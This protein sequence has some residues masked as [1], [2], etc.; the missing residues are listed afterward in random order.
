[1]TNPAFRSLRHRPF[2]RF[3][4]GQTVSIIGFWTQVVAL[5]W[6]VYRLTGST[7]M[8]GLV[9]FCNSIPMLLV[10][11]F[12]GVLVDRFDRRKVAL[13]TQ[14]VQMLQAAIL[15]ALSFTGTLRVEYI[16][17]LALLYGV[18][19]SFDAPARQA[20]LPVMVGGRNDLPNAIALNSA[21]MNLGRFVGPA[22]A[23]ALL[24]VLGEG[25]CFAVNALSFLAVLPALWVLPPSRAGAVPTGLLRELG[26]GFAW[27]WHCRPARR[28]LAGLVV[29]SFTL[30]TYMSMMPAF[31]RDVFHGGA[32]LQGLLISSAGAGA[33]AGTALLSM[34]ASIRGLARIVTLTSPLGA[35]AL[36]V[37][38][39]SPWLAV[40]LPALAVVGF[41]VIVTAAGINTV[42]QSIVEEH[43]R[44]RVV[45]IYVMSFLGTAPLGSLALGVLARPFGVQAALAGFGIAC[46]LLTGVLALRYPVLRRELKDLYGRL[47]IGR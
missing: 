18:A 40:A 31:A 36:T 2:R 11:P 32:P 35:V 22:V 30:P 42:L 3:F 24:A 26:E 20:L 45:S 47:G 19:W 12:A 39:L 28:L 23:G 29:T 46:L 4:V 13:V 5:S 44:A 33:L 6:T 9:A 25:G 15:A 10:S 1:M 43:L 38:A 21:I 41:A 37:F 8:L 17:A 16:V 14:S 7:Q 34:R 27:V